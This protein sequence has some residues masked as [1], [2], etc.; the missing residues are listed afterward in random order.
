MYVKNIFKFSSTLFLW[1]YMFIYSNNILAQQANIKNDTFW[2][3]VNGTYIYSQGGGIFKFKDSSSGKDKFYWYGVHY[4]EA[5]LYKNDPSITYP[6][7]TFESVTCYS[8]TDLVNWHFEA[9]VLTKEELQKQDGNKAKW[10][11][12]MGVAYIK[13]A[14][15]Y[16]IFI[17]HDKGVL[18]AEATTPTG[19]FTWHQKI[20]MEPIIGTP[21]TG[22]QTVFTDEETGK[23]Y[24]VYCYGLGRNK[25]YISELG[26]KDGRIGLLDCTQ[27]Y[28]GEGR[29]G[30]CLFKYN[31]K[32]YLCAS[33]LYGWDASFAYY[34]VADS[35]KGPYKPT[36]EMLIMKG[37]ELDYAHVTQTGFFYTYKINKQETVIYCG[38]RWANFA[39]NGLGYNQWVPLSFNNDTPIFN[40]LSSWNFNYLTGNWNVASDNNYVKNGSFEADRKLIPSNFKPIQQQL[41]GWNTLVIDGT[42][43]SNDTNSIILNHNNS[44]EER[45]IIIGEKSLMIT[46]KV[47][48][49][50]NISQV[51]QSTSSIP[52]KN[53]IYTLTAYIKNE[54]GFNHLEMYAISNGKKFKKAIN[55]SNAEW[56]KYTLQQIKIIDGEVEIGIYADGNE[57]AS[58]FI[59]DITLLISK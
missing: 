51:I 43:V 21:N 57:N 42:G 48:F 1:I 4:K 52:L 39:G 28:K 36:N 25:I 54:G 46:D 15:K 2:K 31:G 12:R 13:E 37:S 19:N 11:G 40:S 20:D 16:A 56:T 59:D 10:V 41:L 29:E 34:L 35:V 24:L 49:K 33:N 6:N 47:K 22:D 18:V 50:R 55:K 23:S 17:Q 30:N 9:N 32:Y 53:G 8:S 58:C 7:C 14:N 27:V 44:V 3:T 45:K 38:D 5:E 26:M